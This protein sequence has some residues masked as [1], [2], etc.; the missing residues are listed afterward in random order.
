[1]M[2]ENDT[3]ISRISYFANVKF[4]DYQTGIIINKLKEYNLYNDSYIIW[5]SDHGDQL[6]DHNLWRKSYPY[7]SNSKV[8]FIIKWPFND[9]NIKVKRGTIDN[10]NIVE[11]RDILPT[12]HNISNIKIPNNLPNNWTIEGLNINCL[13]Y[14]ECNDN[15]REFIDLEHNICYNETNHWNALT[16]GI[17]WKYIFHA[18]SGNET[19]FYLKNDPN[20]MND[21]ILNQPINNTINDQ[22]ILWRNRLIDMFQQQNR[23]DLWV[24][25]HQLQIRIEGETYSPN[26]PDNAAPYQ[27]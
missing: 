10:K 11:L 16:D 14:K 3:N 9:K 12:L 19:L 22:L 2:R 17:N 8:P 1:M 6:G 24:K 5:V 18:Y 25:H 4:I 20:E 26:Y 21:L 27:L 23:G 13:L 15:W 7:N